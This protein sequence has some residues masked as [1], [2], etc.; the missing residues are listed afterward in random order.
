MRPALIPPGTPF[1][2][3]SLRPELSE[4]QLTLQIPPLVTRDLIDATHTTLL[5]DATAA[6]AGIPALQPGAAPEARQTWLQTVQQAHANAS[7]EQDA[8][9]LLALLRAGTWRAQALLRESG[10][11]EAIDP[12]GVS[13]RGREAVAQLA[14]RCG[15]D[16]L[17]DLANA[18]RE[19]ASPL[20][21]DEKRGPTGSSGPS[22]STAP[23]AGAT[24][25]DAPASAT[26]SPA[27]AWDSTTAVCS[28]L[29]ST[30]P[31]SP[32]AMPCSLP[33]A[34]TAK[35]AR[36]GNSIPAPA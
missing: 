33:T 24:P 23:T 3:T 5:N 18:I 11:V 2:Y 22:S 6:L 7:L 4:W 30:V 1:P 21:E 8:D 27:V 35:S 28:P 20:Q 12:E 36:N 29:T 13:Y 14:E 15:S 25:A 32:S 31:A 9:Y 16:A 26:A 10:L 19:A 17:H 34:S